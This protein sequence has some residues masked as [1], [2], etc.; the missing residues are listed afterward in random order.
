MREFQPEKIILFG[1]YV[2]GKLDADSDVDLLVVMP[3]EGSPLRQ[4]GMMLHRVIQ[5]VGVLPLDLLVR[6]SEQLRERLAVGD[7]F[8]HEILERGQVIY[9][10]HQGAYP[11]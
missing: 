3:F 1:S 7:R 9:E 2:Y 4:A 5:T 6:T 11:S 10:A 8:M